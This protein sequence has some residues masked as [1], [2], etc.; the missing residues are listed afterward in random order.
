MFYRPE[1]WDLVSLHVISLGFW[2]YEISGSYSSMFMDQAI[3]SRVK[4][5]IQG[6]SSIFKGQ[7]VYSRIKQYLQG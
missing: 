3:S 1:E 6:S 4:E 7:R 2:Q 5:C